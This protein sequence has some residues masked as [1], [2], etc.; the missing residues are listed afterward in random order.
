MADIVRHSI[1]SFEPRREV[2][3]IESRELRR[4]V[5]GLERG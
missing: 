1:E 5:G 2:L 4:E 3:I